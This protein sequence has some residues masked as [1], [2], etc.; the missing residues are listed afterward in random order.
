MIKHTLIVFETGGYVY[1]AALEFLP[2]KIK[3]GCLCLINLG[4][5]AYIIERRYGQSR[6]NEFL[7]TLNLTPI[8]V[9]EVTYSR[10]LE[11]AHI[12]AGHSISEASAFAVSLANELGA[13][14]LTGDPEFKKVEGIAKIEWMETRTS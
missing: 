1:G 10:V 9:A 7:M 14:I 12:K 13:T 2:P 5:V 8:K 6:M 11:A 3:K 4:E